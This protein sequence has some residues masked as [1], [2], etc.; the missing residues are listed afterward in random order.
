MTNNNTNSTVGTK[1]RTGLIGGMSLKVR[2]QMAAEAVIESH[3]Y[4]S[5]NDRMLSRYEAVPAVLPSADDLADM[6]GDIIAI[7]HALDSGLSASAFGTAI[8]NGLG[9]RAFCRAV[10]AGLDVHAFSAAVNNG[11][12]AP[13]F[14]DTVE[15]LDID[16][17]NW[18]LQCFTEQAV[19]VKAHP[20]LT[21]RTLRWLE[22][23]G[24]AA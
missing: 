21:E 10:K 4:R 17:L 20:D 7:A 15:S 11:L 9:L 19:E 14:A 18:G 24:Y 23:R 8:E 5:V 1:P 3:R 22:Q 2:R 13:D 6:G 16:T 12:S